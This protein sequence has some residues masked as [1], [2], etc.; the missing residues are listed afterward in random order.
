M[1]KQNHRCL[2]YWGFFLLTT[3]SLKHVPWKICVSPVHFI[4]LSEILW[5]SV[6]WSFCDSPQ[7][8]CLPFFISFLPSCL[9]LSLWYVWLLAALSSH[10]STSV[11]VFQI[12]W[13]DYPVAKCWLDVPHNVKLVPNGTVTPMVGPL[14]QKHVAIHHRH[15][16]KTRHLFCFPSIQNISG[17]K[18]G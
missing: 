15:N 12:H 2:Y 11:A 9:L 1:Q 6:L 18:G 7:S 10:P 16:R 3:Y 14:E 4:I 8:L 13:S 5:S 17:E